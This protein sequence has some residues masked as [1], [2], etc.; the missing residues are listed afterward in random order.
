MRLPPAPSAYWSSDSILVVRGAD[1]GWNTAA[2]CPAM[3]AGAVTSMSI[4]T[5]E[6][7]ARLRHRQGGRSRRRGADDV[8]LVDA[9]AGR[10]HREGADCG[11]VLHG[12]R[13][14]IVDGGAVVGAQRHVDDVDVVGHRP[15]AVGVEGEVH[16]LDQGDA[17]AGGGHRRADLDGVQAHPGG[18]AAEAADDVGD[19]SAV[20]AV[21]PI[22]QRIGVRGLGGVGPVAAHEVVAADDLRGGEG[23]RLDDG[24]VVGV[25]LIDIAAAAQVGVQVVD[26]G[27]E[28][29]HPHPGAVVAHALDRRSP[30][31]GHGLGQVLLEV[32]D[33]PDGGHVRVGRQPGQRRGV[34]LGED[35]VEGDLR[36]AQDLAALAA[37]GPGEG[38]L[39]ARAPS[40][41]ASSAGRRARRWRRPRR[42]GRW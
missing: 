37:Q 7:T 21:G 8:R 39:L 18:D 40:A 33:E 19:V 6:G 24:R 38:G 16:A 42:P 28:D 27:V 1:Q 15:V 35:G 23:A 32:A 10:S 20:A 14:V 3:P 26:A 4:W 29:R 31:V 9:V 5:A 22:I 2:Y 34:D 13:Q 17:A 11:G 30:D 36:C 41:T 25:V 12:L